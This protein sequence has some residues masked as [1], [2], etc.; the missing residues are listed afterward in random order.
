MTKSRA[1]ASRSTRS[2]RARHSG[3]IETSK[4]SLYR[5]SPIEVASS[6]LSSSCCSKYSSTSA[7]RR[8]DS[9]G[10]SATAAGAGGPGSAGACARSAAQAERMTAAQAASSRS[11]LMRCLDAWLARLDELERHAVAFPDGHVLRVIERGIGCIVAI[12]RR[13][14]RRRQCPYA[15]RMILGVLRVGVD[16]RARDELEARLLG[17]LDHEGLGNV[18]AHGLH[19]L[20][21]RIRAVLLERQ[22]SAG[23][24]CAGE[25]LERLLD[26]AGVAYPAMHRARGEDEVEGIGG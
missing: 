26:H 24:E 18:A 5:G 9:A 23:F 1:S 4:R 25:V 17:L 7:W 19:V 15:E 13:A 20:R 12:G 14:K 2:A 21:T 10:A 3:A 8:C 11:T 16:L 6:G 22:D